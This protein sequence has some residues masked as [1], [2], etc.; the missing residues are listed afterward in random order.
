MVRPVPQPPAPRAELP[1]GD[2][3]T[4]REQVA[5]CTICEAL[6]RTRTQTVFGVG[7]TSSEWLI[8]GE[9]P[10]RKRIARGAFVGRAGNC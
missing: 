4:L 6:C 2:W 8:I 1:A 10:G 7:N 9:A 5:G 3:S